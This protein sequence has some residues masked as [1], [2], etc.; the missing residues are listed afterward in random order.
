[1]AAPIQT[2]SLD[3]HYSIFRRQIAPTLRTK[4][5]G[6]AVQVRRQYQRPV[7]EF[8]IKD[9]HAIQSAAEAFYGFAQY[10]QGDIAFLWSGGPW[11]TVSTPILFGFGDGTRTE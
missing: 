6:G 2:L 1:M 4:L 7:Y 9:S 5:G 3:T 11:G 8:T 10:H